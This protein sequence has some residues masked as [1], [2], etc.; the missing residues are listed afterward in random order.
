MRH[1]TIEEVLELHRLVITQS[2]GGSGVR[3]PNALDSALAQPR[4]T[5]GGVN[6]YPTAVEKAPP[7]VYQL[8][9][10]HH[11]VDGNKRFVI[12]TMAK[13]LLLHEYETCRLHGRTARIQPRN[14]RRC[15]G[16]AWFTAWLLAHI[17]SDRPH[18]QIH[19]ASCPATIHGTP[20]KIHP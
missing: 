6:L 13:T 1:L 5:F 20:P 17:Q 18:S 16:I 3:D 11:C 8:D 12:M 7:S 14:P 4:M 10:N 19:L 15:L 2:G 9:M